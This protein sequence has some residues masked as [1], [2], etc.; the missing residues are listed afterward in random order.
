[1]SKFKTIISSI[2]ASTIVAVTAGATASASGQASFSI[3]GNG[4]SHNLGTNFTVT[5][6]ENSGALE[7][8]TVSVSMR[9]DT[10]KL[11]LVSIAVG[12]FPTCMTMKDLGG[13][14]IKFECTILGGKLTGTHP[15]GS[16]TFTVMDTGTAQFTTLA[17]S[18]ILDASTPAND[19]WNGA[20]A[21]ASHNLV[22]P[23]A[24]QEPERPAPAA[25]A[26]PAK[27]TSTQPAAPAAVESESD[28]A[29]ESARATLDPANMEVYKPA[30]IVASSN[31]ISIPPIA[32]TILW[33]L[34]VVLAG[35][36]GIYF[37]QRNSR[38]KAFLAQAAPTAHQNGR[39]K[40]QKENG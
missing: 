37:Q 14:I 21:S 6:S 29:E 10:A 15:I 34:S 1:M 11:K 23:P 26:A 38:Q 35:L 22:D 25:S 18:A 40:P 36:A 3:S 39:K 31:K 8:N 4:S 33:I 28:T 24:P 9:Y 5:V 32:K 20:T 30:K 13:G 12:D 7:A 27:R 2:V 16:A 19:I 17:G